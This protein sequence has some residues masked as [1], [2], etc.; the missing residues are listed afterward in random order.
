MT[1]GTHW[2]RSALLALLALAVL[3]GGSLAAGDLFDDDY[4]DCPH[5]T[6]LR[7]GEIAD[8]TVA[9]D[10]EEKDEVNVAWAATDPAT[11]GLGSNA[12][13]TSLV[14]ILSDGGSTQTETLSLGTRK[15][16]FEGVATGTEVTVQMAIVVDTAEGDY[17][18]SDILERS[19][20]QSL[21][22]PSFSTGWAVKGSHD[23]FGDAFPNRV[24][25]PLDDLAD[26]M[27]RLYYIGYNANFGNYRAGEGLTFPTDP[28]TPRLRIGLAHG[29]EDD[30]AR[31][32]VKFDA[33]LIRLIDEDGDVVPEGDDVATVVSDYGQTFDG[34]TVANFTP[35]NYDNY[36]V[37]PLEYGTAYGFLGHQ[38]DARG[39]TSRANLVADKPINNVR[40]NDGGAITSPM[41][42]NAS[43]TWD[44]SLRSPTT[45]IV[46][47]D[48]KIP[49]GDNVYAPPPDAHRDF[50]IDVLASDQTYT[51]EAWAVNEDR[52][53]ISPKA[54]LKVH[55]VAQSPTT[56]GGGAA[57]FQDYLSS[58]TSG[59]L[60]TTEFTVLK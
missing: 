35:G 9:R 24:G 56:L 6:R 18:I 50:P 58:R 37:L 38:V 45:K 7:D 13:S 47:L 46:S 11:W 31:D 33:Y 28:A 25:Y 16:T 40:I 8:L 54:T 26:G 41:Y 20:N 3:S 49:Q 1:Q 32:D 52:E 22:E 44:T 10:A 30:D 17:L 36:L 14:V 53:V 57:R 29:G 43:I 55:P 21:T 34:A 4:S 60:L 42:Q 23:G 48:I 59:T 27:G 15:A 51:I 12:Y 19:I 5:K 39:V 2:I